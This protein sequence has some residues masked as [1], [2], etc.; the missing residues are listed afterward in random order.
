M[1]ARHIELQKYGPLYVCKVMVATGTDV[2]RLK[3]VFANNFIL[4]WGAAELTLLVPHR[5]N[6]NETGDGLAEPGTRRR[7]KPGGISHQLG[8][9]VA[10]PQ[11]IRR[12]SAY[13]GGRLLEQCGVEASMFV[14]TP[15]AVAI[16]LATQEE[17]G[18]FGW[19]CSRETQHLAQPPVDAAMHPPLLKALRECSKRWAESEPSNARQSLRSWAQTVENI[20]EHLRDEEE[21]E[22]GGW[23]GN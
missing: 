9:Q 17:F 1:T 2:G 16:I 13:Q 19:G 18:R 21:T 12:A 7:T 23:E 3:L 8:G 14:K 5:S 6:N 4:Q 20:A 11:G 22:T 15:G 10:I